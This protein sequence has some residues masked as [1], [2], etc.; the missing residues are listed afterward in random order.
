[1]LSVLLK[2]VFE[3]CHKKL[4]INPKTAPY[5]VF[6]IL[7]TFVV[8]LVGYVFDVAPSFMQ[9]MRTFWLFFTNQ[10][11]S[12][13][14]SEISELGLGKKQ[15]LLL[16]A[17]VVFIFIISVI[18]ERHDKTTMR[19]LLDKKPFMLRWAAVFVGVMAVVVFGIYGSGFDAAD[20]VY[21]QF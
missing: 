13:G 11:L 16:L 2:P 10:S 20:F 19:E 17:G 1:M 3:W 14:W 7:R 6:Q 5:T 9:A 15:Y 4:H 18:Q 21:M 8:I 12:K